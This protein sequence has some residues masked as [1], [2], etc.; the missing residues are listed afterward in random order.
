MGCA[1][2]FM[3][4]VTLFL[5]SIFG[6]ENDEKILELYESLNQLNRKN[7]G[8]WCG[9]SCSNN[10]LRAFVVHPTYAKSKAVDLAVGALAGIQH[11]SGEWPRQISFYQ[12]VN[13]LAH[14]DIQQADAQLE[15]AF[16]RIY[17]TQGH[18]GTWGRSHKEWKTFLVIHALKN[19]KEL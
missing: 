18:D 7:N 11:Q 10:I 14:L 6:R 5:A 19:K 13:A 2:L 9:W 8:R 3:T 17:E 15:K 1:R 16:N 12:T 4:G